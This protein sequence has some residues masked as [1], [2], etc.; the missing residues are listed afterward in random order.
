MTRPGDAARFDLLVLTATDRRQA[1]IQRRFVSTMI[2][3]SILPVDRLVVVPDPGGRR[4]GSGGATLEALHAAASTF[5]AS[6]GS[7]GLESLFEGRRVAIVHSGGESRRLPAFAAIGK[8]LMPIG[9]DGR[10]GGPRTMLET[11]LDMLVDRPGPEEGQLVVTTGDAFTS[12]EGVDLTG[13]GLRGVV[14]S[15]SVDR[16][17]RHGVY[18]AARDG[19]VTDMLQKPTPAE[20][21]E[22]GA[23]RR[24]GRLLVDTGIL[25]F[26]PRATALWLRAAGVDRGSDGLRVGRGLL[27]AVRSGESGA[28]EL[29]HELLKAIPR[30][31]DASTF[32]RAAGG[33]PGSPRRRLLSGWR[34]RVRGMDFRVEI[35]RSPPF[36]HPGTTS[37][38]LDLVS[39]PRVPVVFGADS[40]IEGAGRTVVESS[41]VRNHRLGLGGRNLVAG[42]PGFRGEDIELDRGECLFMIPVRD[43]L[44]RPRWLAI[45]HRE[46]DDF[47]T[48]FVDGGTFAGRAFEA[49]LGSRT[50]REAKLWRAGS[51]AG[52]V[53]HALRTL[54]ASNPGESDSRWSLAD[55]LARLDVDRLLERRR[56]GDASHLE[57]H[58]VETLRRIEDLP[59]ASVA[60]RLDRRAAGRVAAALTDAAGRESDHL[61]AARFHAA[62]AR[63]AGHA[64]DRA[65]MGEMRAALARV[66]EAVA[67]PI[68]RASDTRPA[69]VLPDQA[70]WCAAPVRIDLAGG[71]SDTPPMCVDFGGTVVNAAV[72][73]HGKQ[74]LQAVAKRLDEPRIVVHSVDL[75]ES[76]TFTRTSELQ[77]PADPSDWTTL[78]RVALQL[79]GVVPRRRGADLKR[80]LERLGGGLVLT[81]YSAVP[82]GS[83]LGT[84]S[85]LGATVLACLDRIFEDRIDPDV[86]I[87]RTSALEQCMTTRGGWQDQVGGVRGGIKIARTDPGLVQRP[88]IEAL[89]PPAGFIDAIRERTVLLYSGEKRLARDI[90]EKVV[91]RHL[92]RDPEA[93]RIVRRLKDGA[94]AMADAVRTGDQDAFAERLSEYWALKQSFDPSASNARLEALVAPHRRDLAAWELPGAGGGGFVMMLAR[95]PA[96]AD[97]IRR[98]I[99]RR[100]PNALARPFPLEIDPDGLRVT[101]L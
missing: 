63:L 29:Y 7:G 38:Y 75:G 39:R 5:S 20:A 82:K 86:L 89:V 91:G 60:S 56:Q 15:A 3:D 30:E 33:R 49:V 71:W 35:D 78:P 14:Q 80:R 74:P 84:S 24:G 92:A 47:K 98:R 99:E 8:V 53:R 81:L 77:A 96:A 45:A 59:A 51:A 83:G 41:G 61:Q 97:R 9:I 100:P 72:L 6:A 64:G 17:A 36:R 101:V 12:L 23:V 54:H 68:E 32:H 50:L 13:P 2:E 42:L 79:A 55:G 65:A 58:A 57:R 95:D 76:R 37:E 52:T 28:L 19:R 43:D 34:R 90:L 31:V 48:P 11:I 10:G 94:E 22:A 21:A 25:S 46:S 85:I 18:V 27:S 73:L 16:G 44:D 26:D 69:I 66:G 1:G 62:A 67:G 88:R 70:V 87:E 93:L 4:V 40:A